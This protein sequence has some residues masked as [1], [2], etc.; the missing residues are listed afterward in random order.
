[1]TTLFRYIRPHIRRH[2]TLLAVCLFGLLA[3]H[4]WLG[5]DGPDW[6][7]TNSSLQWPVAWEAPP[8]GWPDVLAWLFY[9]YL[10]TITNIPLT[11]LVFRHLRDRGWVL[12]RLVALML[13][14]LAAWHLMVIESPLP[15]SSAVGIA[16][17]LLAVV[18]LGVLLWP[19]NASRV[20]RLLWASRRV[21]LVEEA[22]F[23][24]AFGLM[25]GVRLM[26]PEIY[27]STPLMAG[28][29][30]HDFA[31]IN[32]ILK[33]PYMPP[34]DPWM[35]GQYLT[36]YYYY[37]HFVVSTL[38]RLSGVAPEVAWNLAIPTFFAMVVGGAFSVGYNLCGLGRRRGRLMLVAGGLS[39]VF[40]GM[41]AGGLTWLDVGV[42]ALITD[43][44][45][46][47]G[48]LF[49]HAQVLREGPTHVETPATVFLL[50]ELHAHS[51]SMPFVILVLGVCVA[52]LAGRRNLPLKV[53]GGITIGTV[54]AINSWDFPSVVLLAG[55][56][57]ILAGL[58]R[59][60]SGG[61]VGVLW[62][63]GANV[64]MVCF[65]ALACFLPYVLASSSGSPGLDWGSPH[66]V[67]PIHVFI[68]YGNFL[69]AILTPVVVGAIRGM[70]RTG[71]Q[72]VILV[73]PAS[74][75]IVLLASMVSAAL[76]MFFAGLIV[77][78]FWVTHARMLDGWGRR[79]RPFLLIGS[80]IVLCFMIFVGVN[81]VS[82]HEPDIH[83]VGV[84]WA[85][86]NGV[87]KFYSIVWILLSIGATLF[88]VQRWSDLPVYRLLMSGLMVVAV[89]YTVV[90]VGSRLHGG[91]TSDPLTL[92]GLSPLG[93]NI[94]YVQQSAIQHG[95]IGEKGDHYPDRVYGF[96][97]GYREF[98]RLVYED[99]PVP[100]ADELA[101]V[102]WLRRH[103]PPGAVILE[104]DA[105][106]AHVWANGGRFS[107][108]TGLPTVLGSQLHESI[109]RGPAMW[110]EIQRRVSDIETIYGH[111]QNALTVAL[112][113]QY[114]ATYVI[115]GHS[116]RVFHGGDAVMMKF[117]ALSDYL[118]PVFRTPGVS[119]YERRRDGAGA[120]GPN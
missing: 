38:V 99:T 9:L 76:S 10:F 32:A 119:I 86:S 88:L 109:Y 6:L 4:G 31:I 83:G 98:R 100:G 105:V 107:S 59:S 20:I 60:R 104:T 22:V 96:R 41:L 55:F 91:F 51:M 25:L 65:I 53:L 92:N 35:A 24:L 13:V 33:S 111:G 112:L 61:F 106:N 18:N 16:M 17:N 11:V 45:M 52:L 43:R 116:E 73:V 93:D 82:V 69:L 120:D 15:A 72:R 54:F 36:H 80:W 26:V 84:P 42:K 8:D 95:N 75:M 102:L 63:A 21:V 103:A 74:L 56:A 90:L 115:V 47:I 79:A 67:V 94:T 19:G 66:A 14:S 34:Y 12:G 28:E 71:K 44:P 37:G 7:D 27:T 68:F 29:K 1:M 114:D 108:A 3:L 110:D 62:E 2:S 113:D 118:T 30:A 39:A 58:T 97:D 101:A 117:D 40:C 78:G 23:L 64:A 77:V 49:H 50:G 89:I 48:G 5:L 70:G 87:F 85:N 81:M 46:D 57:F